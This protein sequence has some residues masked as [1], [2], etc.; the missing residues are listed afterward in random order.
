MRQNETL[1]DKS[2]KRTEG[3]KKFIR[4]LVRYFISVLQANNG[5]KKQDVSPRR[6]EDHEAV[7]VKIRVAG[8]V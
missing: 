7:D 2:L 3:K 8:R 5:N 6:H 1:F 4:G